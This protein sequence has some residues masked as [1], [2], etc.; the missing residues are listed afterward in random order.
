MA[1][2]GVWQARDGELALRIQGD[3]VVAKHAA[4]LLRQGERCQKKGGCSLDTPVYDFEQISIAVQ[5]VCR[6]GGT[7]VRSK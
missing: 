5:T 7:S 6:A 4:G 3:L 2:V 1:I